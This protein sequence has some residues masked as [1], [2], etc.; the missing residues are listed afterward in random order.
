MIC[1]E[2]VLLN[3]AFCAGVV[4]LIKADSRLHCCGK[5]T[6]LICLQCFLQ[7]VTACDNF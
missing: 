3:F 5:A 4:Y 2:L 6:L 7:M 1:G